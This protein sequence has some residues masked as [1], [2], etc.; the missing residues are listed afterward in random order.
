MVG[1]LLLLLA[2]APF[3]TAAQRPDAGDGYRVGI[4]VGGISTVGLTLEL[5]R[6]ARSID[7]TLGTFSF[8]DVALSAVVKQYFRDSALRPFVGAGLW[9]MVASPNDADRTGLALV[10]RLPLGVDWNVSGDH[11]IGTEIT[12]NR[13]L[14]IRRPDSADDRPLNGRLVPLPGIYYR[15]AP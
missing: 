9:L 11:S 6:D 3:P 4:T 1:G 10:A 13:A 7:L 5:Y 2:V 14:A 12:I 8:R 15:W